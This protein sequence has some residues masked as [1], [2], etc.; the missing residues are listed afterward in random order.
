MKIQIRILFIVLVAALLIPSAPPQG[1]V[2]AAKLPQADRQEVYLPFVQRP[3]AGAPSGA[4]WPMAGGNVERTSSTREEV[5]GR[6]YPQWYRPIEPYI[7]PKVQII[8]EYN[9]LYIATA[10]GLYALDAA[11]GADRW[12]FPTELPLGHAP[13]VVNQVVYV[14]G[15]DKNLYALDAATG[16]KLW[17]FTARAGFDTNPLV[18]DG[19]VFAGSRDGYF[20]AIYASGPNAGRQAWRFKTGGPIHFSAAYKEGILY[21]ASDD[22]YAYAL[23]ADSGAQV[24]R[25]AKLPGAGFHS[26]WP[27]I[28]EDKVIFSGS[29]N[30]RTSTPPGEVAWISELDRDYIF[31]DHLTLPP[32]TLLGPARSDGWVDAAKATQYYTQYPYRRTVFVLNRSNGQEQGVTPLLW[33]G[34]H[35]GNRYPPVVGNDGLLYQSMPY[36]SQPHGFRGGVVGWR[37]GS[38]LI[39]IPAANNM[40]NDEPLAYA[41]GGS[42]IYYNLCCDR[43]SGAVDYRTPNP[44]RRDPSREWIYF[45]YNL[46]E[47]LPGYSVMYNSSDID[48]T[49]GGRNGVYGQHGDQNPPIPYQGRV[50]M[51]RSNAVIA[52]GPQQQ[53]PTRLTTAATRQ[54]SPTAQP[55]DRTDL[56]HRLEEEIQRMIDSGHLRPAYGISGNFDRVGREFCGDNLLDYYANPTDNIYTLLMALPHLSADMQQRTRAYI[57]AE[58]NRFPPQNVSHAGW[59]S[60][61]P[62]EPY[63]MPLEIDQA[64][65][66]FG[67]RDW[68]LFDPLEGKYP[69]HLFYTLWKYAQTF[70]GARGLFDSSRARLSPPPSNDVLARYPFV[71]NTYIAGYTGY[72]N[73]EQMAGYSETASV[74]SEL[75]RMLNLR[76]TNFNKDSPFGQLNCDP[77]NMSDSCYCKTMNVSRNFMYLVPELGDYLRANNLAQVQAAVNE[78]HTVAPYWFATRYEATYGEG[79]TQ[80]LYDY[81]GMFK[82]RALILKEPAGELVKYLDTP[83]YPIGDL[84]YIQNLVLLLSAP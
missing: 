10:R 64:R 46:P 59:Q 27:V 51:H 8:A 41:A 79:V 70:G 42:V 26:W 24:W 48:A 45:E 9:T 57:Q 35:A 69:P 72:L 63:L 43:T 33:F 52:F 14:G 2:L 25:S 20:Y 19:R 83:A 80:P 65:A 74:R 54:V 23:N 37:P 28:Y 53:T 16:R 39:R 60:G 62:R 22:G 30:Y 32:G 84:F 78:Y 6:L 15:M 12:V 49:Y 36:A 67:P 7:S 73:L 68:T 3:G 13:T 76:R 17:N 58:F 77:G 75:N 81:E 11:T 4:G 56:A 5:R 40:A 38:S 61:T 18:A 50:Y 1:S 29:P 55:V 31:P 47:M 21:F 66:S 71:H 82:A 34:T 44:G